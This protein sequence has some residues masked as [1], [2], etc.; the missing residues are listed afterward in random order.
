L[1]QHKSLENAWKNHRVKKNLN[2]RFLWHGSSPDTINNKICTTGFLRD[3]NNTHA[4]GKGVYFARDASYSI[5]PRYSVPD[6][7]TKKQ[8]LLYCQVICGQSVVG[9]QSYV[10]PPLKPNSPNEHETMVDNVQNPS[11]IVAC[12]DNQSYPVLLLELS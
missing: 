11:V 8:Y 4:Y 2:V 10:R 5:D 9:Q 6:P 7:N 3:F 1:A 12:N